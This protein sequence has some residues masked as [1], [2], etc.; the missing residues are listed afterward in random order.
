MRRMSFVSQL[1]MLI[2]ILL[3]CLGF[4]SLIGYGVAI[5]LFDLSLEELQL[6]S[7]YKAIQGLKIVQVFSS[8]GTYLA[9]VIIFI[10]ILKEKTSPILKTEERHKSFCINCRGINGSY[11]FSTERI[12]CRMEYGLALT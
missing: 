9:P 4:F 10:Y 8:L 12:N 2:V 11:L 1:V 7:N 3:I 6:A 5:L